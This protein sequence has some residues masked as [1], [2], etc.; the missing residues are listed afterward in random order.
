MTVPSGPA[1]QQIQ[2][3]EQELAQLRQNQD[4]ALRKT[5]DSAAV[6]S[7]GLRVHSDGFIRVESGFGHDTFYAGPSAYT[8]KQVTV[9]RRHTGSVVFAT[10]VHVPTGEQFWAA[11]DRNGNILLS[12]DASSGVGLASPWLS[13]AMYPLFSMGAGVY[14]Y[15][16][17]PVASVASETVLWTGRIPEMKH[18]FVGID[19]VWG[20]ASGSNSSTYRLKL[21][22]TQVGTW[23]ATGL[24]VGSKGPFN[25]NAFINQQWVGVDLTVQ[26]SGT[27]SVAAQVAGCC[28]RGS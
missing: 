19:G 8:G 1:P 16:N 28:C 20:Q 23:G 7:G 2:H 14:S 22:G 9:L 4:E 11:L 13:I 15:M 6:G 10:F 18:G 26:A 25:A 12:D 5:L 21:N 27:G 24:E 3:I 17:L